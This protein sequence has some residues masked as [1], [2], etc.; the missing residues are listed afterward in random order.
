MGEK[1]LHHQCHNTDSQV[2]HMGEN[3]KPWKANC[4]YHLYAFSVT[5]PTSIT[6]AKLSIVA[7]VIDMGKPAFAEPRY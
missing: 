5:H 4:L 3:L 7:E 6:L 1:Q 2:S